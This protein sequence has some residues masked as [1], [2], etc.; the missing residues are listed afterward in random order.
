M[1][2]LP[3]I[4]ESNRRRVSLKSIREVISS[5][6]EQTKNM[7]VS[8][9]YGLKPSDKFMAEIGFAGIIAGTFDYLG[10]EEIIDSYAGKRGS[11][12]KID[13]GAITK[14][15][16]I[17]MLQGTYQTLYGTSEYFAHIPLNVLLG[18]DVNALDINR[19][20]LGRFLDDV[21]E[22]GPDKLFVTLASEACRK[23][24][25]NVKEAHLDSTSFS[26]DGQPKSEDMCSMQI[27]FGY[28]RDH[29]KELPQVCLLGITDGVSR[30]P[31]FT[32][33]VSGNE[34]DKTSFFN[35]VSGDWSML[36][37]QFSE[38]K[39]L[40]G[41]SALCTEKILKEAADKGVLI[42]TRVPDNYNFVKNL[43][44][45]TTSGNIEKI[46]KDNDADQNFGRWG[47]ISEIGGVKLKLLVVKNF[48]RRESKTE[49]VMRRAET[50]KEKI[51][52]AL[53][54]MSTQPAKC[55]ADAEANV[56]KLKRQCRLC[57]IEDIKYTED[58]K[59]QGKGRPKADA[60]K[61]VVAVKV[62]GK[63]S[64]DTAKVQQQVENGIQFVVG[65]TDCDKKWTMDEL[66]SVYK[67]QSTIERMWRVSKNPEIML[68]ALYLKTPHRI[69]ALMWILS[70][71]LLVFAATE[72]LMKKAMR[73]KGIVMPAPDHRMN[74]AVPTLLRF[75]QYVDNSKINLTRLKSTG[76]CTIEGLTDKF[77]EIIGAMGPHWLMYYRTDLY[78]NFYNLIYEK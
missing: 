75:K 64:I 18:A 61:V 12:V 74:L 72:Y 65:T 22:A 33:A 36:Q 34:S 69:Q 76:E 41:D 16:T 24:G 10:F 28:S 45:G 43:Y 27:N 52:A 29:H 11:H 46:Y 8:D 58:T 55:R 51:E 32:K 60:E 13:S 20:V 56:E 15:L 54:K 53:K 40:V 66:L 9:Y 37:K 77:V 67:R 19:E 78:E 38:L 5:C 73:E 39:Y 21:F 50:E 3:A 26:Y 70:V 7:A 23:M 44:E 68:N 4:R 47:G 1:T 63:V 49:T 42:V 14:A 17:Q 62:S 57:V 25:I 35:M 30:M 71:T 31:L 48:E 2:T 59:H 6:Y